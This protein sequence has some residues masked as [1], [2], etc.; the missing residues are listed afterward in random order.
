MRYF[1]IYFIVLTASF[2]AATLKSDAADGPGIVSNIKVISDK[3]EDVSTLEDWKRTY[4]KDGMSD[5]EKAVAIWK[6]VVKY[7]HQ[8]SPAREHVMGIGDVHDPMKVIHVYGYNMCCCCS[9]N[10]EGL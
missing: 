8:T 1:A 9:S 5:Q 6:T 10:I 4:I 3:V 7:R 2:W